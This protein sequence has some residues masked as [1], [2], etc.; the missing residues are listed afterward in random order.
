MMTMSRSRSFS[1]RASS[2]STASRPNVT[3][4]EP[5][6]DQGVGLVDEQHPIEGAVN[7]LVALDRGRPQVFADEVHTLGFDHRWCFQDTQ[8]AI[9]VGDH[10][11]DGRLA[12]ARRAAENQMLAAHHR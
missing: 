8:S 2:A 5:G 11:G 4:G 9:D 3:T 1:M 7:K 12:G 6:L 10:A